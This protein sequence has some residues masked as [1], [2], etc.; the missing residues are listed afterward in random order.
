MFKTGIFCLLY[1]IISCGSALAQC[2][3]PAGVAG[4]Q[5]YNIAAIPNTM[6]VCNGTNWVSLSTAPGGSSGYVQFNKSGSF[7]GDS[8]LFWDNTNKRL[9]IGTAS[10]QAS[11]NVVGVASVT[12]S[13]TVAG[14]S[15]ASVPR[16]AVMFFNLVSCPTGWTELVGARGRYVVG[17]PASGTLAGTQGTALTDLE[18]RAVGTHNHGITDPGHSHGLV[19]VVARINAGWGTASWNA[20]SDGG[21][22]PGTQSAVTG[23]TVNNTGV[24]AGTNAPY[25]QLRVCSKD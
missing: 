4:Q 9:G 21:Y 15:N 25:I 7:G 10:P 22:S 23:I 6:S 11:L 24:V 13:I 1:I 14:V 18:N 16:G 17:L 3:T 8:N 2:A 20:S 12:A 19:S 5:K